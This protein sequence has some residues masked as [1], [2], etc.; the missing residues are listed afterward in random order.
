MASIDWATGVLLAELARLGIDE[1]T[2]VIFTSDNG[3]RGVEGGSN[4]PL[5]GTKGTTWEG[6]MRVPCIARWPR[7]IPAGAVSHAPVT[8]MDLYPTFAALAGAAMPASRTVD[9]RNLLA[10]LTGE[11][12]ESPHEAIFYYRGNDLEAVR[13]G[14]WKLHVARAGRPVTE[15]YD[16]MADI[17]EVTNRFD[18]Q[19]VVVAQLEAHAA[20]AR[21]DLGDQRLGV[22]GAGVR[23]IGVVEEPV[24]LTTYD[25][26]HPYYLA[27]YD[28]PDRG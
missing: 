9:G 8:A 20:C 15:L 25:A 16:L 26:G 23:S 4:L 18:E 14:R 24:T 13:A 10:L 22:V 6:G 21:A 17:G 5:R 12:G 27:E 2:L 3:S 7:R 11:R 28:L 1:D 19:P